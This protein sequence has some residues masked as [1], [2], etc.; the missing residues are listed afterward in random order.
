MKHNLKKI[1]QFCNIAL[2]LISLTAVN[3]PHAQGEFNYNDLIKTC[4]E[5]TEGMAGDLYLTIHKKIKE[6]SMDITLRNIA[7]EYSLSQDEAKS[8]VYGNGIAKAETHPE[9]A[10]LTQEIKIKFT[11]ELTL[12]EYASDLFDEI[13]PAE[14][15]AN[16]NLSDSE[17]DLVSDFNIVEVLLF[18]SNAKIDDFCTPPAG[19]AKKEIINI[20]LDAKPKTKQENPETKTS[21]QATGNSGGPSIAPTPPEITIGSGAPQ[22]KTDAFTQPGFQINPQ[23]GTGVTSQAESD[24]NA[25]GATPPSCEYKNTKL[26]LE[27]YSSFFK[28]S[29]QKLTAFLYSFTNIGEII[30]AKAETDKLE[31][32]DST[33]ELQEPIPC[34]GIFCLDINFIN[35]K[36]TLSF[37]EEENCISCHI[38]Y[39]NENLSEVISSSIVPNFA[40]GMLFGTG[41][42]PGA[43]TD[44]GLDFNFRIETRPI[45]FRYDKGFT[46]NDPIDAAKKFFEKFTASGFKE[47]ETKPNQIE[48]ADNH[49]KKTINKTHEKEAEALLNE[50]THRLARIEEEYRKNLAQETTSANLENTSIYVDEVGRELDRMISF[51]DTLRLRIKRL[52]TCA[53]ERL[54][55]TRACTRED[56]DFKEQPPECQ[57]KK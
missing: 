48:L 44:I 54:Q 45:P 53:C 10:R 49:V 41:I 46:M 24:M 17:F 28:S 9:A 40:N 30:I 35:R 18:G 2:M 25:G 37:P 38:T 23:I 8:I 52:A 5:E 51:F 11:E 12:H 4:P 16:G 21:T 22:T 57:W 36:S 47:N 34:D 39:I 27:N 33:E 31:T 19:S 1:F 50:S 15:F 6:G 3:I 55:E 7:N 32:V 42:C 43:L 26:K 29:W 20:T 14:I 13:A 56:T